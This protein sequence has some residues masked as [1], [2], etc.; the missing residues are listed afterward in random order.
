MR[1][2]EMRGS[3]LL[4]RTALQSLPRGAIEGQ[5]KDVTR[6]RKERRPDQK[7]EER[8]DPPAYPLAIR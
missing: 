1:I 5:A 6:Q 2:V 8:L 7:L 3:D 4:Y